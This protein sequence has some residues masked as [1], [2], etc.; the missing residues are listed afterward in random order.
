M[1]KKET[2]H[3]Y[4]R[5][6]TTTQSE[7]GMSLQNQR[8]R[9]IE[10]SKQLKMNC[11]IWNEGGKSS[12]NDDLYNRP[13][14]LKLMEGFEDG[15]VKY[16]YVTD[17][18]R[19]S[20]KSTTWYIILSKLE[21]YNITLYV[22]S[23][24]KYNLNDH[25]DKLMMN[26]ISGVT[27]F[28][29]SQRTQ[30]FFQNKIRKFCDG[31]FIHGTV[32]FGY[33]KYEV[34]KGKKIKEHKENGKVVRKIFSLFS[35]GKTIKDIQMYLGKNNIRTPTGKISWMFSQ[36]RLVLKNKIYIGET[37]FHDKK[38]GKVYKGS[39]PPIVDKG[40]WY[41]VQKRFTDYGDSQQQ[42]K[43]QKHDYLLTPLLYCGCCGNR[44]SGMINKKVYRNLYFCKVQKEK[45]RNPNFKDV[46]DPKKSKSVNIDRLNDLVW[47]EVIE[48]IR[49]STVLKEMKKK[50]ILKDE[51]TKGEQLVK[52]QLKE[53]NL[54]KKEL[55]VELQKFQNKRHKLMEM[56]MNGSINDKEY[57]KLEKIGEKNIWE[58][59]GKIEEVEV[60][61]SRLYENK[62][63]VDW[64]KIYMDNVDKWEKMKKVSD[65][66]ELLQQ[67]LERI[68]VQYLDMDKLHKVEIYLKLK[69]FNDKYK[70]TKDFER[71]ERGR[72]LKGREY[73]V[74]DGEK[75]KTMYLTPSKRG[76][77]KK[78]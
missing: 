42:Q 71:D 28:D 20:R 32:P 48:T 61:I 41:D 22:G 51:T 1:S 62:K 77:K 35:K 7:K 74:I 53:K 17:I 46:C 14:L 13:I 65:K 18:D 50:S 11:N 8:E 9:G 23:G 40:T 39:C 21:K 44:M 64:Y 54:E 69:L 75:R 52:T 5:V 15:S 47:Y 66:K 73:E 36:I 37:E 19:L 6:S 38:S 16:V 27:Q 12:Y 45:Y 3:I 4:T 60:Y 63:W 55:E 34:G 68:E 2:L 59:Q 58:V 25:Y 33:K 67:Y 43:K 24:N 56:W 29:N 76:R 26:I 57:E 72:I 49:D 10:V 70:V 31:Y 30:R 78:T